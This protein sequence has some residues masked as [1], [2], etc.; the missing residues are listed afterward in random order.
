[1]AYVF[2]LPPTVTDQ[3]MRYAIG[4]PSDR[5]K[6]MMARVEKLNVLSRMMIQIMNVYRYMSNGVNLQVHGVIVKSFFFEK[7][8]RNRAS[9]SYHSAASP[10]G[11]LGLGRS[12]SSEFS[13]KPTPY[14]VTPLSVLRKI[15]LHLL[16][17]RVASENA[18]AIRPASIYFVRSSAPL[19]GRVS[20]LGR[21][22]ACRLACV[23]SEEE[24]LTSEMMSVSQ[25]LL[26]QLPAVSRLLSTTGPP[27]PN[28]FCSIAPILQET[29]NGRRGFYA[30]KLLH[31]MQKRTCHRGPRRDAGQPQRTG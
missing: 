7:C 19:G 8:W 29:R 21:D 15:H 25:H 20:K 23:C 22:C 17:A 30:P 16:S 2:K 24:L 3:I 31:A 26:W 6:D 11:C 18:A 9:L 27:P 4:Y 12:G 1:M 14:S 13:V 5:I 10:I 28:N